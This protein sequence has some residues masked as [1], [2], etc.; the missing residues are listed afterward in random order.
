MDVVGWLRRLFGSFSPSSARRREEAAL[1][2]TPPRHI[3]IIMDGNRRWATQKGLSVLHGH[4]EGARALKRVVI[5]AVRLG[6]EQLTAFSFSTENWSRPPD[7]V[8][9]LM[10]LF[11]ETLTAEIQELHHE[12]VRVVFIGRLGELSGG[13]RTRIERAEAL[14]AG[15][16]RLTLFVALNYGG[17]A[18]IVDATQ[19]LVADGVALADIDEE[20]LRSRLYAPEMRDPDLVIRTSGELRLSNFLLWQAAYS[21]FYFS[22]QYWPD[23]DEKSLQAA[24]ADY[25]ARER[26]FGSRRD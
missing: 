8:N 23:F 19:R 13:L 4:N 25:A 12:Q 14:T 9:H 7:E 3:A 24:V 15:N 20:A 22:E 10:S 18:E 17:R 1:A 5:E 16:R 2:S 21:E 6:V 11:A 26:R